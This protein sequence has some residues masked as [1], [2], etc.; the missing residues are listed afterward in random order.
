MTA[1]IKF[2]HAYS[3]MPKNPSH[4]RL[5][6]VFTVDRSDLHRCFVDYDTKIKLAGNYKLPSG[7]LLVLLLLT[8]SGELFSTIRRYTEEK[9]LYYRGLRCKN[10]KIDIVES[11]ESLIKY[12]E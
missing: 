7:K 11:N 12:C 10:V 6:E 9:E 3:K 5:L 8:E 1:K 2:S 4:S